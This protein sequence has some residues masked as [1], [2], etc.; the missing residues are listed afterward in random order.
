[1]SAVRS[2]LRVA[3]LLIW[4]TVVWVALWSEISVANILWGL[5]V[6]A[7]TVLLV[8]LGPSRRRVAFRPVA[9]LHLAA[10]FIWALVRASSVVAWEVITPGLQITP[11]VVTAPLRTRSPALITLIANMIS[12][13][14]GTISLDL[15]EDPPTLYIH[16]LHL[17][18]P[19]EVRAN[20][21]RLEELTLRAFPIHTPE[22]VP[23]EPKETP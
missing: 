6:G 22:D 13:T 1:M 2:S 4:S 17:R 14:P 18:S 5:A 11:G 21:R 8:P 7:L 3:G 23:R 16:V 15:G 20:I 10:Y 12:L 9:I 19:E